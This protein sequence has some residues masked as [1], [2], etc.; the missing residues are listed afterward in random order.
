MI[1]GRV[2]HVKTGEPLAGLTV[3]DGRNV[4]RTDADGRYSLPGWERCRIVC[5]C[6]LTGWDADWY[7]F[8][9]ENLDFQ[10]LPVKVEGDF[11]FLHSS[12]T[13]I[14]GREKVEWLD[15]VR[16]E[17]RKHS[18]AF[19]MN[20]GDLCRKEGVARHSR[21]FNNETAL[22]P[23]RN[24]IGN[25][26]Y[27]AEKYGEYIYE[28]YLG[29]TWYSFDCGDVHFAVLNYGNGECPPGY[30][31]DDQWKWLKNDLEA[32]DKK[33]LIVFK[34]DTLK[35][36]EWAFTPPQGCTD[37]GLTGH[38]LEAWV[39]GHYHAN[40]A[41]DHNGVLMICT[42]QPDS[43]GPDSS[44]GGIRLVNVS[45]RITTKMLYLEPKP[46]KGSGYLWRTAPGGRMLHSA[47]L[48]DNG[49][50]Y[51]ATFDDGWPKKCG[52][53]CLDAATGELIWKK[54]LADGVTGELCLWRDRLF[55]QDNLGKL[56]CLDKTDGREIY[57]RQTKFP[58]P[59][60]LRCGPLAAGD[61][62]FAGDGRLVSAFRAKDG[63]PL[64]VSEPSKGASGPNSF[65][66]D[67][68]RKNLVVSTNWRH[69]RA[70]DPETGKQLW[71]NPD[72]PVWFRSA[73]PV[74]TPKYIYTAGNCSAAALDPLTGE[75]KLECKAGCDMNS[76]GAPAVDR[77]ALYYPT[78]DGGVRAFDRETLELL[79]IFEV[80]PTQLFSV[81]YLHGSLQTVDGSPVIRGSELIFAA[82][83][84]KLYIYDK[85]TAGLLES[86]DV[87]APVAAPPLIL[88]DGIVVAD[89]FGRITK[90]G[91]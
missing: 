89:H 85:N 50:L 47:P 82:G 10:I 44:E 48:E 46:K 16:R 33:R 90:Y 69:I 75:L 73:K 30:E 9:K 49:R 72:Q 28:K 86:L 29:P 70:L 24:A 2:T 3:T 81:P 60:D 53:Y 66:Y 7:A 77:R 61:R 21:L 19:F 42:T 59:A 55:F 25:H 80:G 35:G 32:T 41:H 65:V 57:V 27:C 11:C 36:D 40:Y 54:P 8:A 5:V 34:H 17:V 39:C 67:P 88:S 64:W 91:I 31:A 87:G 43:G 56:F 13:E 18:P 4:A 71:I 45:D 37:P 63:E 22:C 23:T 38:G 14:E 58:V 62:V 51:A 74:V 76:A 79:R 26:D 84:G 6:A 20:T 12:D 83:D 78:G 68:Y 1:S 15:Q 52:V